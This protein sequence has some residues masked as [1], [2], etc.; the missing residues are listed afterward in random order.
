MYFDFIM[1]C[2]IL[3][4]R[5]IL[6]EIPKIQYFQFPHL[7]KIGDKINIPCMISRGH[8][9]F[10]FEWFKN[11]EIL[12]SN[13]NIQIIESNDFSRLIINPVT[14]KSSGNYTCSVS[15]DAGFDSFS[16]ILNVKGKSFKFI[17]ILERKLEIYFYQNTNI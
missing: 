13:G 6:L 10:K 2:I 15:S 12:K 3:T 14:E 8:P 16:T 7:V 4:I 1:L 11:S 5:Y 9:P 17:N